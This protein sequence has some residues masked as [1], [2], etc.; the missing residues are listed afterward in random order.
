[1]IRPDR[2]RAYAREAGFNGIDVLPLENDFFRFYQL[3]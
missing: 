1:V 3:S 2:L